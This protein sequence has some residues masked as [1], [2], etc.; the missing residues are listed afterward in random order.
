MQM[1][2]QQINTFQNNTLNRQNSHMQN[3]AHMYNNAWDA[4]GSNQ[5]RF[6]DIYNQKQNKNGIS[7]PNQQTHLIQLYID[8]PEGAP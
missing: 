3:Q 5:A 1:Q 4:F 8:N 7:D 2:N 6:A